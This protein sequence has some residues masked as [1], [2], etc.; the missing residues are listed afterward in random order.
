MASETVTE[1]LV[2]SAPLGA[3]YDTVGDFD[4]YPEWLEEFK[5]ATIVE[6][7]EDG[8]ADR[9]AFVAS[10]LGMTLRMTLAYSYDD[11]RMS[12]ELVE[13]NILSRN[14]GFYDMVDNGDGTTTLTYELSID[15]LVP[16]PALLRRQ[17]MRRTVTESLRAIKERSEQ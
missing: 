11:S 5:E 8:W 7:R 9:V 13:A 4:S 12:W 14:D 15:T 16:I 6:T 3:V 2:I 1:S 17:L 10:S